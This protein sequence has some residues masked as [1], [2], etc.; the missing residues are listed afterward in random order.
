M[1]EA[2]DLVGVPQTMLWTL[3]NRAAESLRHDGWLRDDEAVRLYRE[4]P[5]DYERFFGKSDGSHA[6][7]ATMFDEALV[8]WLRAHPGGTVIELA[9]GLETQF[10]RCDDGQVQWLCVDLPEAIKIRDRYLPPTSPRCSHLAIDAQDH[11]WMDRI[12]PLKGV[13]VT[14]QGLF[15]YLEEAAVR[16]IV[17]ALAERF[18]GS[19]LMFDVISRWYSRKTL[20]GMDFTAHYRL[21]SMPWGV[22][23][24]E[25]ESTLCSWHPS[26][27]LLSAETYRRMRGF[28]LLLLPKLAKFPW[29]GRFLPVVVRVR[30]SADALLKSAK[31]CQPS[32]D[33]GPQR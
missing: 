15:M 23:R 13:F 22:D 2:S 14:A 25:I 1:N 6:V 4:I 20:Q 28:P 30:F 21:P 12:D 3:H 33:S 27:K 16:G 5:F 24:H 10:H 26:I 29:L 8:P 7:R 9:C 11:S 31:P 18:P 19:E 17:T 32:A